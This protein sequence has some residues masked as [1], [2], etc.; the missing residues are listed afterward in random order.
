MANQKI[1]SE[2]QNSGRVST[3]GAST[4]EAT[5]DATPRKIAAFTAEYDNG[6]ATAAHASDQIAIVDAGDYY[7]SAFVAFSGT[8]S[9][10]F[11]VEIYADGVASGI[12]LNRKLGTGGDVGSA[13]CGGV[14][15]LSALDV[16]TLYQHSSDG[17]TA[18]TMT[19]GSLNVFRL[20]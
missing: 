4:A 6:V 13:S 16:V 11:V 7:V 8:Q 2:W 17:G 3:S 10:T 1:G 14:L 9:K 19:D 15:A 20:K 5:T 12:R 18:F